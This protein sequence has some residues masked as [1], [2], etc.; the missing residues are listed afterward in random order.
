[1]ITLL[2]FSGIGE[3]LYSI[4]QCLPGLHGCQPR[5]PEKPERERKA[6]TT[7]QR[8]CQPGQLVDWSPPE[9]VRPLPVAVRMHAVFQIDRH[10]KV[11][12]IDVRRSD[13]DHARQPTLDV[14]QRTTTL[15]GS[16][17]RT[18]MSRTPTNATTL[19]TGFAKRAMRDAPC[20]SAGVL[21][22]Q[23]QKGT[24]SPSSDPPIR[25]DHVGWRVVGA[26]RHKPRFS[27]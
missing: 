7:W 16:R 5:S 6:S 21:F 14:H 8:V 3:A 24:G 10:L 12:W 18:R 2:Y 22:M 20:S 4:F 25:R 11:S 26:E 27:G 1:L 17:P 13:T 15:E 23:R 9:E 19:A